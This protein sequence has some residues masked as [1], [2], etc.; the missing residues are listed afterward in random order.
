MQELSKLDDSIS[1]WL[2]LHQ[3]WEARGRFLV[4]ILG[5]ATFF[6]GTRNLFKTLLIFKIRVALNSACKAEEDL[7]ARFL[8][9]MSW[10]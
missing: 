10:C 7:E 8:V 6:K 3:R 2:E 1:M 4:R 9:K 5:I